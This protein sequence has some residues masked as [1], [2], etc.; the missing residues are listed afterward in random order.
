LQFCNFAIK[1]LLQ[2]LKNLIDF[3]ERSS[4]I[5]LFVLFWTKLDQL[6]RHR[7]AIAETG[8][9]ASITFGKQILYTALC[10]LVKLVI[11][12]NKYIQLPN[13]MLLF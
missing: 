1:L 3:D 11:T 8:L 2:H 5:T 12:I 7:K 9:L 4:L 13:L 10:S 6:I